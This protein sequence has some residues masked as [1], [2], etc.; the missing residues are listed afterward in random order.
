MKGILYGGWEYVWG[1]YG[2]T[3]VALVG[4]TISLFMRYSAERRR[5]DRDAGREVS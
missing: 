4:Y 1:A 2:A 3:A 5:R